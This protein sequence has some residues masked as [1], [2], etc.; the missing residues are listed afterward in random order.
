MFCSIICDKDSQQVEKCKLSTSK[1]DLF[2]TDYHSLPCP[3]CK[4]TWYN[5]YV[6]AAQVNNAF[7]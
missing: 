5:Y 2:L 1:L 7:L 3:I 4:I 6:T